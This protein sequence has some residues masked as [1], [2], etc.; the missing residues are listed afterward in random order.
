MQL[1]ACCTYWF[2]LPFLLNLFSMA[3]A[4]APGVP[5]MN[6][7]DDVYDDY[8]IPKDSIVIANMW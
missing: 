6:T 1:G 4:L 7:E 8:F 2:I 5:H 3:N